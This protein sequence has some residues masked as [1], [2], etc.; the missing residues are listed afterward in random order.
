MAFVKNYQDFLNKPSQES[1]NEWVEALL[2]S[3]KNP[4]DVL[5][6][7]KDSSLETVKSAYRKLSMKYHPDRNQGDPQSEE[8]FKEISAAYE[9][10]KSPGKNKRVVDNEPTQSNK[11]N[12]SSYGNAYADARAKQQASWYKTE[13]DDRK[14]RAER[15]AGYKKAAE[16]RQAGYDKAHKEREIQYAKEAEER[17][18][19]MKEITDLHNAEMTKISLNGLEGNCK[20]VWKDLKNW[21]SE[22]TGQTLFFTSPSQDYTL[23]IEV[24]QFSQMGGSSGEY[25]V[26]A[27]TKNKELEL[28]KD[29]TGYADLSRQLSALQKQYDASKKEAE[30]EKKGWFNKMFK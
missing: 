10:I 21:K 14:R 8:K 24:V 27:V 16:E 12:S 19:R 20:I 6:I 18:I 29:I 4:Y 7:P 23:K 25:K 17:K 3:T 30:P 15:E 13:E 2:E 1:I 28:V 26:Q 11:S 22:R 5:G 9:M